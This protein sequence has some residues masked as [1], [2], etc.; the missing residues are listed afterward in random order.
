MSDARTGM[1]AALALL[2]LAAWLKPTFADADPAALERG[3]QIAEG[4]CGRCHAVSSTG[5]SPQRRVIPFRQLSERYPV[6]MLV[7]AARTGTIAGHDEMPMFELGAEAIM[8]LLAYIESFAPA[9][10]R[11]LPPPQ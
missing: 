5:D 7:D 8:A 4:R 3:R 1:A 11:Y 10:A 2:A 6:E 9:D